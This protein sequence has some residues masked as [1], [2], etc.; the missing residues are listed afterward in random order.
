MSLNSADFIRW[1]RS[2]APYIHAHRGKT[3]VIHFGG[4]LVNSKN[5]TN[6][7]HDIALMNSLGIQLVI[8]YCCSS[9]VV[10]GFGSRYR[11]P[12]QRQPTLVTTG[13]DDSTGFRVG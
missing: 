8:V 4:E 12:S 3:F 10:V 11:S 13:S 1:F 6:F 2:A 7:L 5:F 9:I